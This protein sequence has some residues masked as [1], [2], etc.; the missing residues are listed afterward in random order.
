MF[1][2]DK[3]HTSPLLIFS[4]MSSR[5]W[6]L[7]MFIC[8]GNESFIRYMTCKC[9]SLSVDFFFFHFPQCP[10]NKK[11][12][13]QWHLVYLDF[14]FAACAFGVFSKIRLPNP[15]SLRF[16]PVFSSESWILLCSW[17]VQQWSILFKE[18]KKRRKNIMRNKMSQFISFSFSN[19][20]RLMPEW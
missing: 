14:S 10:L 5:H 13:F 17:W 16:T 1:Y 7:G 11:S 15:R 12:E 4:C 9:F 6:A 8:C 2:L 19:P 3:I 18:D 20:E